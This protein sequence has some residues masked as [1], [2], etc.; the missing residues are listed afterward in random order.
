MSAVISEQRVHGLRLTHAVARYDDR[1]E[2]TGNSDEE[3]VRLH[4]S[5]RG[6]YA[7]GYPALSRRF[8][9][10]GPHHSVFYARP[11]EL[12]FVNATPV[13]ETF[14]IAIPVPQFIE[15][16]YGASDDVSRFCEDTM[17]GRASF[18][19]EP[20]AALSSGMESTIRR[21]LG[22]RHDGAL[23][24]LFLFSQSIELL[25][26]LLARIPGKEGPSRFVATKAERDKLFAAREFVDKKLT[27]P[28]ALRDVARAVGLNEYK[29]KRGFRELFGTTVFSY[30]SRERLELA[31]RMLLDTDQTAREVAF[32]LGYATPQH[33]SA[34]F[35]KRF[36]V[37]P[38]SMR[39]NP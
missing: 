4:F 11:F 3:V 18:L 14:G 15:Y 19:F 27:D 33:F 20:S 28:P 12:R 16:T 10:L 13:L 2:R 26:Q 38:K 31:K 1:R 7:V 30:L 36:G 37:S 29:L 17:S 9:R 25:V 23:E 6:E 24:K 22:S 21:M 8:D 5:L 35:K 34:A 32:A 39:K